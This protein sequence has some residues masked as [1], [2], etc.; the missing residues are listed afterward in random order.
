MIAAVAFPT[1]SRLLVSWPSELLFV[2]SLGRRCPFA[3]EP[4]GPIR[5][6]ASTRDVN[7]CPP[8]WLFQRSVCSL[9]HG[10]LNSF[11]SFLLFLMF[12]LCLLSSCFVSRSCR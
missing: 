3:R 5:P 1:P 7:I 8:V 12:L 4:T 9:S 10:L 6:R 11:L 2:C